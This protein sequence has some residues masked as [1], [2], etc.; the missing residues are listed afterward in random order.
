MPTAIHKPLV[1]VCGATG[2]QG[3]SVVEH[4]LQDGGYR[5]RALTRNPDGAP[6]QKLNLQGVE[7]VKC[8]FGSLEQ[9]VIAFQGAYAVYGVTNFWEH[10]EEAEIQQGKNLADAAKT[11]GVRHFIWPSLPHVP[12]IEP[13]HW[14]S[15]ITVEKYL[16]EI[17]IPTTVL[18]TP[19]F[20]ENLYRVLPIMRLTD[21]TLCLDWF[22]PSETLI[23]SFSAEDIGAWVLIA[24]KNPKTWV[25]RRL[26]ICVQK[27]TPRDY[28][29]TLTEALNI[30]VTLREVSEGQFEAVRPHVPDDLWLNMKAFWDHPE[31]WKDAIEPCRKLHPR[32]QTLKRYIEN[33]REAI[34]GAIVSVA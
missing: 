34:L 27:L 2:A 11:C 1:V 29:S 8:D 18:L 7:T 26:G 5:V 24:L 19:F 23:P 12:I 17:G 31:L 6:A 30:P 33:H 9:V 25:G 15:K 4:L 3:S 21:G 22:W 32:A 13:R 10:G 14:E 28:A 20:F 16:N